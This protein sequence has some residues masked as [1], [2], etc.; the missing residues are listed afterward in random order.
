MRFSIDVGSELELKLYQAVLIYKND[1]GN[2]HMATVH[3]VV[4]QNG[5]G[6][7]VL[8]A[9]Q[10]LSTA[11]L[12]ELSRQ[13]GTGCPVEFLPD[14]VVA[15]TPDLLAW[16][17]PAAVRPMFFRT[18]SELQGIS[19]KR[20][21]HP[22]LLFV[23]RSNVL[24]VRALSASRR[25]R[26]DSKLAAAPYWNID[27]LNGAVCAGT[28]RAPKSLTVTSMAAWQRAF[29]Q[30]EFT[31]PGGGGRLTKRRGGTTALWK[32]LAGEERFPLTTLIEQ[33]PLEQPVRI[34]VVGCGGNGSAIV[35]G[36]PY[37]H[38][39]MLAFGHP[40]GLQVTLID[41][42]TVSETNCVRQPFCRTEI[43]FSK[44]IVLAH[45]INLFWG[46]NWQGMQ[47]QIQQIAKNADVDLVVGC[48]DTRKARR[49]IDKWAAH[50][51]VS[52]W[53][54]LGNNA[55]SGQFILGQPMNRVNRKKKHR[56]PTVTELFPEI[57][58][59]G[60][61]DDDQPSCSAAEALT[62]QEP[63]I[64]PNLAYQALG[65]LTQL[66]RHGSLSYHGGFCNLSTGRV[67]PMPIRA[68]TADG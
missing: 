65:M 40:G 48:V 24:Y 45:R 34:R 57:A 3:G 7:P 61:K 47:A 13:L 66:L 41:P 16:W 26:P 36:L 21:P 68:V 43:G 5:D 22:A 4:Q 28:M 8:G 33:E 51:Q 52:Y 18:G 12:R 14:Q 63:F 37:L 54:D 32:S 39:A 6:S 42:D 46:L 35:S 29:F 1:H 38:Q 59:P 9:G 44:A 11:C 19:G 23:V 67:V 30:S 50:S 62:R 64:N 58:A 55:S 27:S 25:P 15:R 49:A 10:L 53:L 56:L 31:H 60:V 17:T 2:R 20:F